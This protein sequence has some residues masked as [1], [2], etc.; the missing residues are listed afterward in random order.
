MCFRPA[1]ASA[2]AERKFCP[3]CGEEIKPI[4]GIALKRCQHCKCDLMPYIRGEKPIPAPAAPAIPKASAAPEAPA[5]PKPPK[6]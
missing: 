5:A 6:A 4:P 1:S 2:E 3:E